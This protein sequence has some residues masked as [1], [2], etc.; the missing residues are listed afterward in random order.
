[1]QT[2]PLIYNEKTKFCYVVFFT[3][4]VD[5]MAPTGHTSRQRWHPAFRKSRKA[6]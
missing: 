4:F 3:L 6:I 1:M 2:L 5:E